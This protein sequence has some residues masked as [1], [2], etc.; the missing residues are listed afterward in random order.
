MYISLSSHFRLAER[1]AC[2][3]L[4]RP[5]YTTTSL[6]LRATTAL[7]LPLRPCDHSPKS[8]SGN[9][10]GEQQ[11]RKER[12]GEKGLNAKKC[13]GKKRREETFSKSKRGRK[14][15][16]RLIG[17]NVKRDLK[18]VLAAAA[19][20][21]A[22]LSSFA[23]VQ[24]T[25]IPTNDQIPNCWTW[26]LQLASPH[27]VPVPT[28]NFVVKYSFLS[29]SSAECLYTLPTICPNFVISPNLLR[30]PIYF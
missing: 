2:S 27:F 9:I 10:K 28:N 14:R 24:R 21:I 8:I 30:I 22:C 19:A 12:R 11:K 6:S 23:C 17:S 29:Y 5:L 4:R 26:S 15:V 7:L 1:A 25:N 20:A 18:L 16:P 13:V 3:F